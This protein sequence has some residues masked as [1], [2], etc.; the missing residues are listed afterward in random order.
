MTGGVSSFLE[1]IIIG[2]GDDSQGKDTKVWELIGV[3]D[4]PSHEELKPIHLPLRSPTS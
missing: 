3:G 1:L 4:R 2:V